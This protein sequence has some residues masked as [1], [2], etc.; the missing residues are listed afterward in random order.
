MT[1]TFTT[2]LPGTLLV[3]ISIFSFSVAGFSQTSDSSIV[4]RLNRQWIASF[5]IR[6]TAAMARILAD[7]FI[8]IGPKGNKLNRMNTIHNVG[9]PDIT[10]VAAIDSASVRVFGST[11][12]VTAY[13][14]FT[15]TAQGQTTKGSNCYSDLYVKRKGIWKAVAG[16]VTV[17][18]LK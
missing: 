17:L 7:D 16:H 3:V 15:I 6:D 4:S 2:K 18:A 14:H 8:L 5:A 13:T 12:L 9:D 11:A 10:T 1:N